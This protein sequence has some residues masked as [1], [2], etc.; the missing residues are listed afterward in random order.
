MKFLA[1]ETRGLRLTNGKHVEVIKGQV[2]SKNQVK[3]FIKNG[4]L[5]SFIVKYLPSHTERYI[6]DR[7]HMCEKLG[8]ESEIELAVYKA[9]LHFHNGD[10]SI[11]RSKQ[12]AQRKQCTSMALKLRNKFGFAVVNINHTANDALTG[13]ENVW[14]ELVPL[15]KAEEKMVMDAA[16]ELFGA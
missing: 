16:L 14:T 10:S 2:Y 11:L 7:E 3:P 12:Q 9:F 6:V 5:P 4:E 15:T 13:C 1:T 8:W